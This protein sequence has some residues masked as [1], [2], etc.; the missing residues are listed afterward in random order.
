MAL[1]KPLTNGVRLEQDKAGLVKA[2]HSLKKSNKSLKI[3]FALGGWTKSHNFS[4]SVST[5]EHGAILIVSIKDFIKSM[6]LT[7]L[8]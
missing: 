7:V 8:I 1:E 3:M 2:L 4:S 6:S 5:S